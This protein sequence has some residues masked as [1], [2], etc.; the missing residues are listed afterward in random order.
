HRAGCDRAG[1]LHETVA[2][3][4]ASPVSSKSA[5]APSSRSTAL[6]LAARRWRMSS[7]TSPTN[8]SSSPRLSADTIEVATTRGATFGGGTVWNHSISSGPVNTFTTL[9]PPA[10]LRPQAVRQRETSGL[11]RRIRAEHWPVCER[12]DRQDIDPGGGAVDA[13]GAPHSHRRPE[14]LRQMHEA[15]IALVDLVAHDAGALPIEQP[16]GADMLRGIHEDID[17]AADVG[18]QIGD[19]FL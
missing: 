5:Y 14:R 13:V 1:K 15:E 18:C 12:I 11:R 6:G 9:T 3:H 7:A 4:C 2:V 16:A 17:L 10:K 8:T 19:G